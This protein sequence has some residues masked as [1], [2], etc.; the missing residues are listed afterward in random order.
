MVI[1]AGTRFQ[2]ARGVADSPELLARD[3]LAKNKGRT[4]RA[5][6]A[7][8]AAESGPAVDWL[9]ERHGV[10][11]SL[12]EGFLYPGHSVARM[13]APPS[14]S[15]G[16]LI[17]ALTRAAAAAG[18]DTLTQARVADLFADGDGRVAGLEFERP[19]GARERVGCRALVLACSGFGGDKEM[20]RRHIPSLAE[21]WFFGHDGNRGDAM[22]WGE[23]LGAALA[24][25]GAAQG[26]GSVATPHGALI[27]WGLMMEGG[28]Q[29][30]AA[31][32]RFSDE[33]RG[34]S[35]QAEDVLAQPGGVAWNIFDARLADLGRQF[36]DFKQAEAAGALVT[37]PT[38]EA[39]AERA[40][41]PA[42]ALAETLRETA[43]LAAG[44]GADRF[45]RDFSAKPAL[46]PPFCA[47]KVTGALF[48][49]QG[50]LAVDGGA[51]VLRAD[52]SPLPNLFAGGGA[53]RGISGPGIDGYLSGNGLLPA[54]TLGR[55]AGR[56][57][58]RLVRA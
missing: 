37:A 46:A 17:G 47:I 44:R 31:G 22:R 56:E 55:I 40:G 26:H 34:Y 15:G 54:I 57:A 12:V 36:E 19:D 35:E 33:H 8:I 10:A 21:A 11:F 23:A 14:R 30:N 28:F 2:R 50:G 20:V 38:V 42:A 52:G 58:A 51:R 5:L 1:G 41:L 32:R 25:M 13:H 18:I 3:I 48:H 29:V 43:A 4:D 6:V 7:A 9:A 45:G 27:T 49:T 53:A 16:E 39:L 24:D